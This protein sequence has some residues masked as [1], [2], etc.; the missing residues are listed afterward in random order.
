MTIP[1]LLFSLFQLMFAI[2]TPG[3]GVG[4]VA[5]RIRF[6]SY[7]LFICC[8]AYWYM[9]HWR[10]GPGIRMASCTK[11]ACLILQAVQL[12]IFLQA[13]LHWQVHWC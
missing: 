13:V 6:T 10:T 7:I 11:W 8:L 5:E 4:A 3:L 2:I 12:C 1:L 9:P